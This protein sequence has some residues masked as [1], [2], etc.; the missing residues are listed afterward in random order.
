MKYSKKSFLKLCFKRTETFRE[1]NTQINLMRSE[2]DTI[3]LRR[4]RYSCIHI[5][6]CQ[7]LR[8]FEHPC[9]DIEK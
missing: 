7:T 5:V 6:D 3:I 2:E 8:G 4:E 1:K 9:Q